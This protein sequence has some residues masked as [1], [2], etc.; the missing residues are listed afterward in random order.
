MNLIS[1]FWD[2][3]EAMDFGPPPNLGRTS[4]ARMMQALLRL[5]GKLHDA[6]V[7]GDDSELDGRRSVV[8]RISLPLGS[9]E[10]FEEMS[11]YELTRPAN[12]QGQ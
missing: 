1:E 3:G 7:S 5:H 4:T 8:Y 11:G 2:V 9:Q 6:V 12:I 10:A